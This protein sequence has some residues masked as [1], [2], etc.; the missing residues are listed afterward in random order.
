[1]GKSPTAKAIARERR[2][3][4]RERTTARKRGRAD[5]RAESSAF[6]GG[7]RWHGSEIRT[8]GAR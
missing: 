1:M 4:E 5:K 6:G 7:D 3:A 8:G 2:E